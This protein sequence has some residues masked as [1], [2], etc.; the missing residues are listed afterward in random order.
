MAKI[1]DSRRD[2]DSVYTAHGAHPWFKTIHLIPRFGAA[3][4]YAL[5]ITDRTRAE[6]ALRVCRWS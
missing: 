6:Q 1:S 3:R 4:I 5:D 2:E